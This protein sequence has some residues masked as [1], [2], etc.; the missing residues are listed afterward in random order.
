MS[1]ESGKPGFF[2][3]LVRVLC[4]FFGVRKASEQKEPMQPLM[5]I[6]VGIAGTFA[7]VIG[8]MF[9]VRWIT[10]P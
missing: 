4:A 10:S 2:K 5:L 3:A 8:L 6:T 9:F 1:E 7:F